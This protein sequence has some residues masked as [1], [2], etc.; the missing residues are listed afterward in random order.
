MDRTKVRG[1]F[2]TELIGHAPTV[3]ICFA[4]MAFGGYVSSFL[5][6][7]SY[8][9]AAVSAEALPGLLPSVILVVMALMPAVFV[10]FG[11]YALVSASSESLKYEIGVYYSQGVDGYAV[12]D[13]WTTLYG[14]IP[15]LGYALGLVIYF[16]SNPAAF[17]GLQAVLAD[18]ASGLILVAGL[19][20][21]ILIPR[22]LYDILDTSPYSVIRSSE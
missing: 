11:M 21:F 10:A 5:E 4:A 2:M 12:M 16:G 8:T 14:W 3:A 15:T 20:T 13:A 6:Y 17:A 9:A 7:A 18:V 1:L 22:K 19:P